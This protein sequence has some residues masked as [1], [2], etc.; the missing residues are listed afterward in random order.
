MQKLQIH[1]Y[2]D[3][4][5]QDELEDYGDR[6]YQLEFAFYSSNNKAVY[7]C[8]IKYAK[9][10]ELEPVKIEQHEREKQ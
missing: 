1:S 5:A 7:L 9:N 4:V 8:E 3:L 2:F 6:I 10:N